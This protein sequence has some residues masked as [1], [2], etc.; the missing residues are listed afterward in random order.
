VVLTEGQVL[1]FSGGVLTGINA[2][3]L[4][5]RKWTQT[6]TMPADLWLVTHGYHSTNVIVQVVD[7]AGYVIIP[8]EIHL[9]DGDVVTITFGTEQTGTARLLFLD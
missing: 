8:E 5:T 3:G 2:A 9:T 7:D 1:G 6:F 4:G